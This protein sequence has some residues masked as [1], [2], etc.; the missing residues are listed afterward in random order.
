MPRPQ[1]ST[2]A[3]FPELLKLLDMEY[4]ILLQECERFRSGQHTAASEPTGRELT[5]SPRPSAHAV[6]ISHP[7]NN[8][9]DMLSASSVIG[10]ALA[11]ARDKLGVYAPTTAEGPG[12]G[13]TK[14]NLFPTR[15]DETIIDN[16]AESRRGTDNTA[17]GTGFLSTSN[18]VVTEVDVKKDED[19][20]CESIGSLGTFLQPSH[21]LSGPQAPGGDLSPSHVS[22]PSQ[23]NRSEGR[24]LALVRSMSTVSEV[25][26]LRPK[27]TLSDEPILVRLRGDLFF[28]NTVLDGVMAIVI[29]INLFF[30]G[31]SSEFSE[32][33]PSLLFGMEAC[34][35]S[36]FLIER[37]L[38]IYIYGLSG[39]VFGKERAWNIVETCL[40]VAAIVELLLT[41]VKGYEV[42]GA[43]PILRIIR[44]ARIA[45]IIRVLR[46]N[47]FK[48]FMLI[49]NGIIGGART[50]FASFVLI[51]I[52]LYIVAMLLRETAGRLPRGRDDATENF[53]D[54]PTSVYTMFR[55]VVA[56]DCSDKGGRPIFLML[57]L[58]HG[59]QY[60]AI[61]VI[62]VLLM[63][64]GLFN[65]IVAIYVE[66]T[67]AAA[68]F[69]DITLKYHRLQNDEFFASKAK[70][71]LEL[72]NS[73]HDE[74]TG[75]SCSSGAA[76]FFSRE[77][78]R[79]F[80][81]KLCE[82]SR[83]REILC[84]L[85]VAEEDQ[86]GLFDTLD[87]D[88]GGSLDIEELI[89]GVSKLRGD[90]RRADIISVGLTVGLLQSNLQDFEG[91]VLQAF[92]RN[93]HA[94]QGVYAAV[95]NT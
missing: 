25:K 5:L 29:V 89:T 42:V 51:L 14:N 21:L 58:A 46:L 16:K 15:N 67:V 87:V 20:A 32:T 44:L 53:I 22:S 50:L 35:T 3:S 94:L 86:M 28:L 43:S 90:P 64:F 57:A 34:F 71:L 68:K 38:K 63:T 36:V 8:P 33:V 23:R 47:I 12:D 39:Y 76:D 59:W 95:A 11:G 80:F 26:E 6:S 40:V 52:P 66:N 93:N 17:H 78:S 60:A 54:L 73:M 55:C 81:Q 41:S 75:T 49:L 91:R 88:K 30:V 79:A 10:S 4:Y 82:N 13:G 9:M 56:G 74:Q 2:R 77:I 85:D 24:A 1:L 27:A 7:Q 19:A 84:E 69:N 45:K 62:T 83:F 70:E 31:I 18:N 37:L 92:K 72:V 48:E 65:V 61:Y